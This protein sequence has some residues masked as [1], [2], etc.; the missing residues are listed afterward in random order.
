MDINND[1]PYDYEEGNRVNA[2]SQKLYK[3]QNIQAEAKALSKGQ[4][5]SMV[6][7]GPSGARSQAEG[8]EGTGVSTNFRNANNSWENSWGFQSDGE[9]NTNKFGNKWGQD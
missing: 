3:K 9:G 5:K 4:G 8:S 2:S 6:G 1:V 7:A